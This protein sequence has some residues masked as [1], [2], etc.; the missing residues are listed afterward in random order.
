MRQL[1]NSLKY[2]VFIIVLLFLIA[3][4]LD[5]LWVVPVI[6]LK[7]STFELFI[8]TLPLVFVSFYLPFALCLIHMI[9]RFLVKDII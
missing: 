8:I 1:I 4:V 2:V 3:N 6:F 5:F 9:L 7:R